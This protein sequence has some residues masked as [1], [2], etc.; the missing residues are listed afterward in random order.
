MT[1]RATQPL[2]TFIATFG[3]VFEPNIYFGL[4]NFLFNYL[5]KI[6][7][8]IIGV[9]FRRTVGIFTATI[10]IRWRIL[11]L[12]HI[13]NSF[14]WPTKCLGSGLLSLRTCSKSKSKFEMIVHLRKNSSKKITK[15]IFCRKKIEEGGLSP[16]SIALRYK[17]QS[18]RVC[19]LILA[20]EYKI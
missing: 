17:F 12:F 11:I 16:M 4:S 1:C 13:I 9:F 7:H 19:K 18:L 3:C 5:P 6:K 8:Y 2:F 14:R 15:L 20:V 10:S